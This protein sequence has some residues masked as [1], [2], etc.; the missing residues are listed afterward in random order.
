MQLYATQVECPPER[1]AGVREPA[2]RRGAPFDFDEQHVNGLSNA[3]GDCL[4]DASSPLNRVL[5]F[6]TMSRRMPLF[7]I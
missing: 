3:P 7:L 2:K 5:R 6:S 4:I 1:E